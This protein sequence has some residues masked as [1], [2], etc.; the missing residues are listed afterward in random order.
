MYSLFIEKHSESSV[1]ERS[2]NC[3][4]ERFKKVM[5]SAIRNLHDFIKEVELSMEEWKKAID[6]SH[7]HG[8]DMRS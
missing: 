1:I 8:T 7:C 3:S 6:F 5:S 4:N 2:E